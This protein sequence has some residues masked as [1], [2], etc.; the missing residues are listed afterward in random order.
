MLRFHPISPRFSPRHA[1]FPV[2]VMRGTTKGKKSRIRPS[3]SV[4][5]PKGRT[6]CLPKQVVRQPR[7]SAFGR[8]AIERKGKYGQGFF[9][10]FA[11]GVAR[12]TVP[13]PRCMDAVMPVPLERGFARLLPRFCPVLRFRPKIILPTICPR[14]PLP[15][16]ARTLPSLPQPFPT[17]AAGIVR[18]IQTNQ[19]RRATTRA[20][21]CSVVR[22]QGRK[23]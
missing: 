5:H 23:G 14:C 12:P 20:R 19:A 4:G 16:V 11:R 3:W 9:F 10:P 15:V 2:P 21:R 1:I 18:L 8:P 6:G 17:P 7:R 13:P 22:F